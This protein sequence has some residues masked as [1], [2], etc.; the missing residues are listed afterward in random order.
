MDPALATQPYS[1]RAASC[2]MICSLSGDAEAA[3]QNHVLVL[4]AGSYSGSA[5]ACQDA[6]PERTQPV[7]REAMEEM[8]LMGI[9]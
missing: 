9:L 4:E 6:L 8:A 7:T 1:S 3:R 2:N 5:A